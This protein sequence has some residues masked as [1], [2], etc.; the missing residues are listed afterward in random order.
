M[1][2]HAAAYNPVVMHARLPPLT[3]R[4]SNNFNIKALPIYKKTQCVTGR[5]QCV[6]DQ[7]EP[8]LS[9]GGLR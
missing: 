8:V 3:V 7:R 1:D 5:A 4:I 9:V 2:H 6:S